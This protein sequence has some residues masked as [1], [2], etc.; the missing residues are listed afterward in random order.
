MCSPTPVWQTQWEALRGLDPD[1][2]WSLA[3]FRLVEASTPL[4]AFSLSTQ[5]YAA[6]FGAE[7]EMVFWNGPTDSALGRRRRFAD[8]QPMEEAAA[9]DEEAQVDQSGGEDSNEGGDNSSSDADHEAASDAEPLELWLNSEDDVANDAD[10]VAGAGGDGVRDGLADAPPAAASSSAEAPVAESQSAS[11]ALG[12]GQ[13]RQP[14]DASFLVPGGEIRYYAK[15][16]RFA[17]MCEHPGH[18]R[19]CRREKVSHGGRI[20]GGQGRPL[21]YLAAWLARCELYETQRDHMVFETTISWEERSAAREFLHG[22]EGID[23]LF[24]AERPRREGEEDEPREHP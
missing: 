18:S 1:R 20:A 3:I 11:Q 4:V 16:R 17:A 13:P 14:A 8:P 9:S 6:A 22:I 21:G 15:T 10:E 23:V 7:Q 2:R 19:K 12:D 24:A 5:E